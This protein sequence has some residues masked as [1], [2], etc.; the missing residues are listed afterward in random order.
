MAQL[1]E[2]LVFDVGST[3]VDR[4]VQNH[5]IELELPTEFPSHSQPLAQPDHSP[6]PPPV[7]KSYRGTS[8]PWST[9]VSQLDG[10]T[11]DK[12]LDAFQKD[13]T[14]Y[15]EDER[16]SS[17]SSTAASYSVLRRFPHLDRDTIVSY[18]RA[19]AK[20]APYPILH[21]DSLMQTVEQVLDGQTSTQWGQIVCVL[22]VCGIY[23]FRL[24]R[25]IMCS[26]WL[27]DVPL[28]PPSSQASRGRKRP[29]HTFSRGCK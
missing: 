25:M 20:D 14:K 16:S 7:V 29:L 5:F 6:T 24:P 22:M 3:P 18:I 15:A 9:L 26:I 13:A 21:F 19:Y 11:S 8:S 2:A 28:Q 23:D 1:E 4:P 27:L 17:V 12:D 10:K